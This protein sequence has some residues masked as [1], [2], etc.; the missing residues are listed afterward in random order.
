M[1]LKE[2]TFVKHEQ[3][4]SVRHSGH[5][6]LLSG[7]MALYKKGGTPKPSSSTLWFQRKRITPVYF[8]RESAM[9]TFRRGFGCMSTVYHFSCLS[10]QCA[11][12]CECFSQISTC[13]RYDPD[14]AGKGR[15]EGKGVKP[16]QTESQESQY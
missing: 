4:P 3:S 15:V 1:A 12:Y 6:G 7:T 5:F 9:Y 2:A 10:F 14:M 13:H 8:Y 16:G 11:G